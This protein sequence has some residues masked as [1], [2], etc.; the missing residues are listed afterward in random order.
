MFIN[1]QQYTKEFN[2]V[3]KKSIKWIFSI[4][5]PIL[6][7]LIIYINIDESQEKIKVLSIQPNID[8]YEEKYLYSNIQFLEML[9]E[10]IKDYKDQE[11]DYIISPETYFA[12]GYG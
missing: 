9:I 8:P 5:I 6:I 1:L 12:E 4:V 10:Q 11:I 3:L 2:D 7:S